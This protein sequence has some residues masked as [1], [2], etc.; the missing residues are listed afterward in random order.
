MKTLVKHEKELLEGNYRMD[1]FGVPHEVTLCKLHP[2]YSDGTTTRD[3]TVWTDQA[4]PAKA[5]TVRI[6]RL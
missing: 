2:V 3:E 1:T 5:S 6:I 4:M